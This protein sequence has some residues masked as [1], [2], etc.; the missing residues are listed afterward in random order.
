MAHHARTDA[1]GI[2]SLSEFRRLTLEKHRL[3]LSRD[4]D[5]EFMRAQIPY[6][7]P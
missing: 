7:Y 2:M 5:L 6:V 3:G 4:A 1:S